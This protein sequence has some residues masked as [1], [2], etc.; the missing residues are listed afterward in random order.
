M[1]CLLLLGVNLLHALQ[2]LRRMRRQGPNTGKAKVRPGECYAVQGGAASRTNE[3]STAQY[4]KRKAEKAKKE[5][6]E[7]VIVN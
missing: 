1:R 3:I 2:H 4:K 7:Y 5:A 6:I